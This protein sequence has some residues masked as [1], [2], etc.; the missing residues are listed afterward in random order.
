M[1]HNTQKDR[2]ASSK[3][4]RETECTMYRHE[5]KQPDDE[6][7]L[8]SKLLIKTKLTDDYYLTV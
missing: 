8:D 3:R 2:V 5:M 6:Q 4:L 7:G 1:Q